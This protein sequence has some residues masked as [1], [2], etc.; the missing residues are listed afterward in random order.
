MNIILKFLTVNMNMKSIHEEYSQIYS[1]IQIFAKLCSNILRNILAR[2]FKKRLKEYR[3]EAMLCSLG[4][5][6]TSHIIV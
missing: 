5:D 3:N 6:R 2:K 4:K 1:N